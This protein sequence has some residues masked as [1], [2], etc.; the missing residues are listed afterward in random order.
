MD[1]Y[2][3]ELTDKGHGD[4]DGHFGDMGVVQLAFF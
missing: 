1:D 2:H 4:L 3:A